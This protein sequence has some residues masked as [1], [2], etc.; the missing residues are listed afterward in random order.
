[1]L[2]QGYLPFLYQII[3]DESKTFDEVA[4]SF[5]KTYN[6]PAQFKVGATMWFLI[7]DNILNLSQKLA[8][9]YILYDMNRIEKGSNPFIPIIV[10]SL[11]AS[12]NK[13]EQKLLVDFL[14]DKIT[15]QNKTI[16]E[17]K[18][19]NEKIDKVD[20]PDID[21]YLAKYKKM[22]EKFS[23]EITDWIRPVIYDRKDKDKNSDNLPPFDIKKLTP[24]EVSFNYFE[25]NYMTYYPNSNYP[26]LEDEP[27][28]IM[29]TLNFDF[30]WDFTMTP[31]N[32]A[33]QAILNK[34]LN[35]KIITEEESKYALG[36]IEKNPELL[37]DV[38]FTPDSLMKLI[39]KNESFGAE[40]LL[41]ISKSLIFQK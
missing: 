19:E 8:S 11:K 21:E 25:P 37:T 35:D 38:N 34:P 1:M 22:N 10:E 2:L 17:F 27:M 12:T 15:Y 9:Y 29:P 41:K 6:K 39:D 14:N 4:S 26:F 32:D 36:L 20:I 30:V 23:T 33:I 13:V 18:E 3:S 40:I 5:Q 7:K 16:S 31:E 24:E 28:W